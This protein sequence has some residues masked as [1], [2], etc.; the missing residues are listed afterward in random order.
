MTIAPEP[1][2]SALRRLA[3]Q[4]GLDFVTLDPARAGEPDFAEVNPLAAALLPE[5]VVRAR[6]VLPIAL[7]D[8]VVTLA[9]PDPFTDVAAL[10][11]RPARLVAT[12]AADL[13]AALGALYGAADGGRLGERLVAAG[14]AS[15]EQVARALRVQERAGGRL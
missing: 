12:P 6:R 5:D 14:A 1:S 10:I 9:T 11:D 15:A 8:G 13:D 2:R 7:R 4:L 3:L